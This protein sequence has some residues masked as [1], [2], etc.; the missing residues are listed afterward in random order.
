MKKEVD[1]TR[2]MCLGG[3]IFLLVGLIFFLVGTGIFVS[4]RKKAAAYQETTG[5]VTGFSQD[6][7][8]IVTYEVDGKTYTQ[9]SNFIT[10][11]VREGDEITIQYDPLSPS[12]MEAGAKVSKIL[13]IVFMGMGG[14]FLLIGIF[15][16]RFFRRME[17]PENPW[18]GPQT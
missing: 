10:N 14:L 5:V 3:Y 4:A 6:G 16:V 13:S 15:W 1:V 8:L 17:E 11:T 9:R 7:A 12:R 18:A 2:L